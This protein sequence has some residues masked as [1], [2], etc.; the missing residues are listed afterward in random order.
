MVCLHS[1]LLKMDS[2]L[3]EMRNLQEAAL[4]SLETNAFGESVVQAKCYWTARWNS[5]MGRYIN[6]DVFP[7]HYRFT[8]HPNKPVGWNLNQTADV[9]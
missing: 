6:A 3:L 4:S 8:R 5:F 7:V 1:L 9:S 2:T